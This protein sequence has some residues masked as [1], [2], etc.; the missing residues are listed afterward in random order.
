MGPIALRLAPGWGEAVFG[1]PAGAV[2]DG[3]TDLEVRGQYAAYHYW[4]Y[5]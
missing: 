1:L 4:F 2:G 3:V 5:Q